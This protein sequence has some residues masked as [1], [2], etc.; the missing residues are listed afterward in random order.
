MRRSL[1]STI[2]ALLC[3][4]LG[5]DSAKACWFWRHR[6]R[7]TVVR[8]ATCPPA[9][10]CEIQAVRVEPAVV[11]HEDVVSVACCGPHATEVVTGSTPDHVMIADDDCRA[12]ECCTTADAAV[13]IAVEASPVAVAEGSVTEPTAAAPAG[14]GESV[15]VHGPTVVVDAAGTGP[16]A[17]ATAAQALLPVPTPAP[18]PP[19]VVT[20]A[21]GE[22]PAAEAPATA[23]A[24]KA[25][26]KPAEKPAEPL[27]MP[28]LPAGAAE[29]AAAA[30]V[31]P[32]PAASLAAA[33]QPR[34]NLFD[35]Y[36][37][38]D[39]SEPA[40][41]GRPEADAI[42]VTPAAPPVPVPVPE[43]ALERA[44]PP[45]EAAEPSAE[46]AKPTVE[47]APPVAEPGK[48]APAAE[49]P[50]T[51]PEP[52]RPAAPAAE[53][54]APAAEDAAPEAAADTAE[55]TSQ[56][57]ADE[58]QRLWTDASGAHQALGWLVA[59]DTDR[60]RILKANGRHTTVAL[61]M[62]SAA[63]RD[64]VADVAARVAATPPVA[65]GLDATVGL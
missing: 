10:A 37:D 5:V 38:A 53:P 9:T 6:C 46:A 34:P 26:E 64:Y 40:P 24:D 52:P 23:P 4:T 27:V 49:T 30:P 17:V 63:D 51:E 60:V 29:P 59:V 33:P 1:Q 3:L 62:L 32:V 35:L 18:S 11:P 12:P 50:A 47:A 36:D 41:K 22:K 54:A 25:A 19:S 55:A 20:P 15:V 56:S 14:D 57:V 8:H 28:A 45:A 42:P 58:P 7:P 13:E 48:P 65:P 61:E 21:S 43:P 16:T 39:M 31:A 44:A 2:V